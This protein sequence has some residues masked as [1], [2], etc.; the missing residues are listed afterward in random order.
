MIIEHSTYNTIITRFQEISGN[1]IPVSQFSYGD[2][3][4]V[5]LTDKELYPQ[6]FLQTP[7]LWSNQLAGTNPT[8]RKQ[9]VQIQMMILDREFEDRSDRLQ[10]ISK[11]HLIGDGIMNDWI[12]SY[13]GDMP[14]QTWTVTDFYQAFTDY[15]LGVM[16]QI[17]L[18]TYWVFDHCFLPKYNP[19]IP[20]PSDENIFKS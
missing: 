5:E 15:T 17:E 14:I 12:R 16:F 8:Q 2:R 3:W 19:N 9:T 1:F 11:C 4:L 7:F 13:T 18:E 20:I 6:V 10:R